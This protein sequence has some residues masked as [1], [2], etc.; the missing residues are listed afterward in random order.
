[1]FWKRDN[2]IEVAG[3]CIKESMLNEK[4]VQGAIE[5]KIEE[6][7]DRI[8]KIGERKPKT[9]SAINNGLKTLHTLNK[10]LTEL[11]KIYNPI[12]TWI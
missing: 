2:I 12:R 5:Q 8:D 1:M 7:R 10:D 4:I 11:H 6:I 9:L 3:L